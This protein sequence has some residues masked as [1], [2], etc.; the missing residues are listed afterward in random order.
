MDPA[1]QGT[2]WGDWIRTQRAAEQ[3]EKYRRLGI[4]E[5]TIKEVLKE[6]IIEQDP[7]NL[8]SD[9]ELEHFI[10]QYNIEPGMQLAM[11]T[12]RAP[13]EVG[14]TLSSIL[15][16]DKP[17]T[18][19]HRGAGTEAAP[20]SVGVR[21]GET[22][23]P[24][25]PEARNQWLLHLDT[26]D[27]IKALIEGTTDAV[28]TFSNPRMAIQTWEDTAA[29]ARG[30]QPIRKELNDLT[31]DL[32]K[33]GADITGVDEN[34]LP[35]SLALLEEM[36][37]ELRS[38]AEVTGEISNE[39]INQ[40]A[41]L[42]LGRRGY[43]GFDDELVSR[44]VSIA[45]KYMEIPDP[46]MAVWKDAL[47]YK[48]GDIWNAEQLERGTAAMI[49]ATDQLYGFMDEIGHFDPK[50][51]IYTFTTTNQ[52]EMMD[53]R[54]MLTRW[55]SLDHALRG[56]LKESAR[57]MNI[58]RKL[59]GVGV[60]GADE[61]ADELFRIGGDKALMVLAQ[62]VSDARRTGRPQHLRRVADASVSKRV[63]DALLEAYRGML[64]Y[65]PATHE[66]NIFSNQVLVGQGV[67]ERMLSPLMRIPRRIISMA[68]GTKET[69]RGPGHEWGEWRAM[70]YGIYNAMGEAF[71]MMRKQFADAGAERGGYD[72]YGLKISE[73]HEPKFTASNFGVSEKSAF[74]RFI[75]GLGAWHVRLPFRL[76]QAEDAWFK[77]LNAGGERA[78]IAWR[79]A[80]RD[81]R[82]K[83]GTVSMK[84]PEFRERLQQYNEGDPSVMDPTTAEQFDL[85]VLDYARRMTFTNRPASNWV[86]SVGD[87]I[88][89]MPK[90]FGDLLLLFKNTPTNIVNMAL[91][92][93]PILNTSRIGQAIRSGDPVRVE[94]ALARASIGVGITAGA[95]LALNNTDENGEWRPLI[96]GAGP[97]NRHMRAQWAEAG[98]RP[99]CL[100]ING[101]YVP[102][103][104][105]EPAGIILGAVT[106]AL[107]QAFYLDDDVEVTQMMS[108]LAIAVGDYA[109]NKSFM[110]GAATIMTSAMYNRDFVGRL[111]TE[112]GSGMA[113]LP[114]IPR[115]AYAIRKDIDP[116]K[117]DTNAEGFFPE[118]FAKFQN[119]TPYMSEQ[120]PYRIGRWGSQIMFDAP[121]F[122]L[123][124]FSMFGISKAKD[125]PHRKANEATISHQVVVSK[126]RQE[127]TYR[128]A[129]LN[130]KQLDPT[131][132]L[133]MYYQEHVGKERLKQ[134]NQLMS[135]QQWKE[136]P[137]D[138]S[139]PNNK[140]RL[141]R[142]AVTDGLQEGTQDFIR[143]YRKEIEQYLRVIM[144]DSKSSQVPPHMTQRTQLYY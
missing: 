137:N 115:A 20:E 105:I 139:L 104:H 143:V 1:S 125:S 55:A 95:W 121:V 62:A 114:L 2:G 4:D 71:A 74:G 7:S 93:T 49:E 88:R 44:F 47:H 79:Y 57:T 124:L 31:K 59:T 78:A 3:K 24:T 83:G 29:A 96:T 90:P 81:I 14:K 12:R 111:G 42:V 130:L 80:A 56:S 25:R 69:L 52:Q 110:S 26:E 122:G 141:L 19:I 112:T 75:D 129:K 61:R 138:T 67:L 127:I 108:S 117:R 118:L 9:E 89:K 102:Y 45:N 30:I 77:M 101:N 48:A 97:L 94:S 53:F 17:M 100:L 116:F 51:G 66:R 120:V 99:Y 37:T 126:P 39:V 87:T 13:G 133:Y 113:P 123:H 128:N 34:K 58:A 109:A 63:Y 68:P 8:P 60:L 65:N 131:G 73:A 54:I 70:S 50:N 11:A 136:A 32:R 76:L 86:T 5:E 28:G 132:W 21:F 16:R 22:F 91:D 119:R 35:I 40:V 98:W 135:S 92:Y 64:L 84:N 85:D 140:Q 6:Q 106:T 107:E 23:D 134:V 82:E 36:T 144:P 72:P 38:H 142:N 18:D 27:D 33:H 15:R 41:K 10:N 46:R 103:N 43:M